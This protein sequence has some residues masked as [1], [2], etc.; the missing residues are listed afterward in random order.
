MATHASDTQTSNLIR[1]ASQLPPEEPS[2]SIITQRIATGADQ[3]LL[4]ESRGSV[5]ELV[6][7]RQIDVTRVGLDQTLDRGRSLKSFLRIEA[8]SNQPCRFITNG[9]RAIL[10]IGKEPT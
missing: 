4:R 10:Q 9:M 1:A 8:D 3:V 2:R 7:E 6:P 5:S